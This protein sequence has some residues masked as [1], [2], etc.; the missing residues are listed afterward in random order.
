MI[1]TLLS[2]ATITD[3]LAET[4]R[5]LGADAPQSDIV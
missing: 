3:A 4:K 1:D 2:C 5:R